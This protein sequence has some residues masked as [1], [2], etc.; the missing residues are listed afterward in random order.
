MNLVSDAYQKALSDLKEFAEIAGK[1][2]G[3][4]MSAI[5]HR[6]GEGLKEMQQLMKAS[7]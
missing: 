5:A 3:D 6:A 1:S 4:A 7:S 2:Q